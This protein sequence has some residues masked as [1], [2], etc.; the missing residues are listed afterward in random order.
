MGIPSSRQGWAHATNSHDKLKDALMDPRVTAIE[1]DLLMGT[2][3]SEHGLKEKRVPIMAHPPEDSSDLPLDVFLRRVTKELASQPGK[4]HLEKHIK[5]DFKDMESVE[6]ALKMLKEFDVCVEE[7]TI[8][9]NADVLHGPGRSATD[10]SVSADHFIETC[11]NLLAEES[12]S[13]LAFLSKICHR[14]RH[15]SNIFQ[16]H[17]YWH[18]RL[19][20]SRQYQSERLNGSSITFMFTARW[21]GSVSTVT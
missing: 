10:V 3:Q 19:L 12:Q 20:V 8:F 6:P 2:D 11:L 5:L 15:F 16:H 21:T 13:M 4:R 18:G 7:R 14:L 9:L 1:A 17:N